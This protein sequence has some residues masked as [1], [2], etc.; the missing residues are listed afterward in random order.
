MKHWATRLTPRLARVLASIRGAG[1]RGR[2]CIEIVREAWVTDPRDCV[3]ELRR[4]GYPIETRMVDHAS[5]GGRRYARYVLV[6]EKDGTH[7]GAI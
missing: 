2:S 6:E 1:S 7:A 3:G 4:L 5:G